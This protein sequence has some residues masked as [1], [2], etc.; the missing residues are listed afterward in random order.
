MPDLSHRP[1]RELLAAFSSPDPT[2]GGGSASAL[3]AAVGASLLIMVTR[4]PRTRDNTEEDRAALSAAA[5]ALAA[6]RDSLADLIDR[7]SA[8]YDLVVGAYKLPKETDEEQARRAAAIQEALRRATEIPLEVM[9]AGSRALAQAPVVARHAHRAAASDVGVAVEL[10]EAGTRGAALNVQI[11]LS[12]LRDRDFAA[13]AAGEGERL[14]ARAASDG[15]R[16]VEL[17]R[18]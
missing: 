7:D 1:F 12:G 2:P 13:G 5:E 8:A 14:A 15:E 10:L 9:R 11:N 4:L 17:L 3:C 16:A 6:T 18:G